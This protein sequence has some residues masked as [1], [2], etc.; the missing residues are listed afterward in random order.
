LPIE[1]SATVKWIG[2]VDGTGLIVLKE[3]FY[4]SFSSFNLISI[5]KL[6]KDI[7]CSTNFLLGL[8]HTK[9]TVGDMWLHAIF[10]LL[11]R[12]LVVY[13]LF[14]NLTHISKLDYRAG[15]CVTRLRWL[16]TWL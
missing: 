8:F 1:T 7:H 13:V 14:P 11:K 4:L 2:I 15:K 3:V 12:H 16:V 9:P 10:C 6:T 5:S